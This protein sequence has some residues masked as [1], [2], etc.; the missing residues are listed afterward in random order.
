MR[1]AADQNF[2]QVLDVTPDA[3]L[4]D[5]ERAYRIGRATYEPSSVATYSIFSEEESSE[6]L[7]R[8]EE[9]FTVLSDARL[10]REYDARLRREGAGEWS[11]SSR[12]PAPAARVAEP[13][14]V[15][16]PLPRR[17][18]ETAGAEAFAPDDGVYD[19]PALRRCRV[20][21]GIELEEISQATKINTVQ[22]ERIETNSYAELPAAVYLRGFLRE[23]ARFLCLDP[24][25][26]AES[27]MRRYGA[28]HESAR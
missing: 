27:Y 9:A 24:Q 18:P 25:R 23:Y 3:T 10:R 1:A 4:Q 20:S 14:P 11:P 22:L 16:R 6:I 13:R 19:G 2:Y 26:V 5:I 17:E 21:R 12:E 28:Q 15:R 7:R 8:I